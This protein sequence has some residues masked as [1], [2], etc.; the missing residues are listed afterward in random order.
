[1]AT[2]TQN[3]FRIVHLPTKNSFQW[4]IQSGDPFSYQRKNA[5]SLHDDANAFALQAVSLAEGGPNPDTKSS[6]P[7]PD[8]GSADAAAAASLASYAA[9][10]MPVLNLSPDMAHAHQPVMLPS[11]HGWDDNSAAVV[12]TLMPPRSE[13]AG[14]RAVVLSLMR[15]V[16]LC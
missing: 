6:Q 1:M 8:E 2:Y 16:A 12:P 14:R 10:A 4:M 11:H 9:P 5:S 13:A 3:E 15:T 7:A